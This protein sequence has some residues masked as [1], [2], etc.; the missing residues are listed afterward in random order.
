[1][2]TRPVSSEL[3]PAL[4]VLLVVTLGA[5]LFVGDL[6]GGVIQHCDAYLTVL[7]SRSFL[8]TG[9]W[10]TVHYNFR[11]S[12]IKRPLQYWLTPPLFGAGWDL[13][14]ALRFW[15]LVFGIGSLLLT[16]AIARAMA[17]ERPWAAPSAVLLLS[18]SPLFWSHAQLGLLDTGHCFFLLT[19]FG[20]TL[21]ASRDARWWTG[22]GAAIGLGFLQKTPVA[23]LAIALWTLTQNL[24][25]PAGPYAWR[26]LRA[27]SFFRVG[28]GIAMT[29]CLFW[30]AV[31]VLRY[32]SDFLDVFFVEHMIDRFSPLPQEQTVN[33]SG[34]P[35]GWLPFIRWLH[36]L[37]EDAAHIW[38]PSLAL[39]SI[40]LLHPKFRA[41]P[42]LRGAAW[43]IVT[44]CLLLA[45]A[46][47]PIYPRYLLVILPFLSILSAVVLTAILPK[48][49]SVP[50][51][52]A[53]LLGMS[54]PALVE[55]PSKT[56]KHT[57]EEEIRA[58]QI[59]GEALL[60]GE[61]PIFSGP[62]PGSPFPPAAFIYFSGVDR[63]IELIFSEHLPKELKA[64]DTTPH[65][66][67]SHRLH[68]EALAEAL[69]P[70]HVVGQT[71]EY[72]I[73]RWPEPEARA[74]R[75][76]NRPNHS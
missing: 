46:G 75:A 45:A 62:M 36:W 41:Q 4:L 32:G 26:Q 15:P 56:K 57:Y 31:Q 19:A 68:A 65:L 33:H 8:D 49:L 24:L 18:A 43:L 67:I 25:D 1:M 47:G 34:H 30:P 38:L 11:P 27:N 51:L 53:L 54:L 17:P 70:L 6:G 16:G 22:A 66:V 69:G 64:G 63:H 23:L 29:L 39:V 3:F 9:D 71:E 59:F 10:L 50:I 74:D 12:F 35:N 42:R 28:A 60:P 2:K 40:A 52:C 72:V 5:V 37:R 44:C 73:W 58:S 20:C 14:L 55:V 13:E 48:P 76:A 61:Q 21:L 7:R